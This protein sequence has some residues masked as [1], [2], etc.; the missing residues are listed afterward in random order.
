[1]EVAGPRRTPLCHQPNNIYLRSD[2]CTYI[3]PSTTPC[4]PRY[5]SLPVGGGGDEC[6]GPTLPMDI[7]LRL[8]VAHD[9]HPPD[10]RGQGA[11]SLTSAPPAPAVN[12]SILLPP[13]DAQHLSAADWSVHLPPR[14]AR[15][16][17]WSVL[18]PQMIFFLPPGPRRPPR[19]TR[20]TRQGHPANWLPRLPLAGAPLREGEPLWHHPAARGLPGVGCPPGARLPTTAA[21]AGVVHIRPRDAAMPPWSPCLNSTCHASVPR[22]PACTPPPRT[23]TDR[24]L[25]AT[26]RSV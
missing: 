15:V 13:R 3:Y 8:R 5:I 16:V 17:D 26:R 11:W 7:P 21:R 24:E 2:M 1:V 14:D 19:P 20:P 9:C 22:S 18:P 23:T 10:A 4:F 25:P 12:W 6:G